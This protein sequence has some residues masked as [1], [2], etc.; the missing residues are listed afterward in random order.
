MWNGK[1]DHDLWSTVT[2]ASQRQPTPMV[3]LATKSSVLGEEMCLS[4]GLPYAR[5]AAR[6][7]MSG[8]DASF[9]GL[10][11]SCFPNRPLH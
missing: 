5:S 1:T 11:A 8:K 7:G 10:I 3:V 6:D 2:P 4:S 9:G